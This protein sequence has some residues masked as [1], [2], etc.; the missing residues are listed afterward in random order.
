MT[1]IQI[2]S[3]DTVKFTFTGMDLGGDLLIIRAGPCLSL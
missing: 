3:L 2:T 1:S